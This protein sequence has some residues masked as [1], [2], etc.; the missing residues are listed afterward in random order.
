MLDVLKKLYRG[1]WHRNSLHENNTSVMDAHW[2][3]IAYKGDVVRDAD[4]RVLNEKVWEYQ[5]KNL[6]VTNGKNLLLDRLFGLSG[7]P[8]AITSVGVG[9]DS[10]AAAVGQTQLNPSVAGSV[11]IQT[12]DA[13]TARSAQ[14]VTI[15]STF[16]TGVANFSWN[17]CGLFNGNTNGTSTMFNRIVIGPFTKSSAVSIVIQ[18]QITQ[19]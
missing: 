19:S 15:Q 4:G 5:G 3:V 8:T 6:I 2:T 9:T 11:L 1:R 12:A 16:G 10:T 7:P 18:I 13:G 14:T 17:E